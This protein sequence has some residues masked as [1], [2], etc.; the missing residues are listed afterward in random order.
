MRLKSAGFSAFAVGGCVR[1]TLL[2]RK[3]HDWDVT[4]SAGT[5]DV[6]ALFENAVPTGVRYGTVTVVMDGAAV[7]VTTFRRDGEYR[8][9][10]KPES[11]EFVSDLGEDLS[12]RDF[13]VNAMAM[14]ETGAITDLFGGREDLKNRVIRCVGDP[15]RRF[16]EDALR[17]LRAVRFSAQLDFALA[18]ETLAALRRLAPL[19]ERLSAQRVLSEL[20]KTLASPDPSRVWDMIEYGLLERFF[21]GRAA[22][23]P[24]DRLRDVPAE[25]RLPAL[26]V[27]TSKAGYSAGAGELMRS[28]QTTAACAACAERAEKVYGDL[29]PAPD[30]RRIRLALCENKPEAVAAACAALGAYPLAEREI[31]AKR[32]V[33]PRDLRVSGRDAASLGLEGS[34]ISRALLRLA[35]AATLGETENDREKLLKML[36]TLKE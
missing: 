18:P 15:E 17:M 11:V 8:D 24:L 7:E 2:G 29:A 30:E 12:R 23:L 19:C 27:M 22:A 26:A 34:E 25:L 16:S 28:L 36:K 21:T 6:T 31:A 3:P 10:R 14:D 32:Y 33:R 4:T 1:D 35:R 13:T 20:Q 5:D 9:A